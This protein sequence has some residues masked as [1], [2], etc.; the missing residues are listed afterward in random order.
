[1]KG[2]RQRVVSLTSSPP[3]PFSLPPLEQAASILLDLKANTHFQHE[4]LSRA[5]D[6][7]KSSKKKDTNSQNQAALGIHQQ[8]SASPNQ[9]T[10]TSSSTSVNDTRGKA[11]DNAQFPSGAPQGTGQGNNGPATPTKGG[12]PSVVIS[13]SAVSQI[14]PSRLYAFATLLIDWILLCSMPL[15]L[16][17]PRPCPEI[18]PLPGNPTFSIVSRQRQRICRKGSGLPSASTRRDSISPTSARE[19]WRSSR[20]SMKCLPIVARN[21]SCRRSINATSSLISMTRPQT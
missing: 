20:V 12:A 1:M 17:R 7:N 5:K 15:H 6:A 3:P 4:Q 2:F 13:P 11:P 8:Q 10:P 19:N 9:G 18:W 21:S 14:A 16:V